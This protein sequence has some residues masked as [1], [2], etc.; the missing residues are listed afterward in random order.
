MF[1]RRF[2]V[3]LIVVGSVGAGTV[4][5]AM[6]GV[7]G[8]SGASTQNATTTQATTPA[9][10]P[11]RPRGPQGALFDAAAKALHLTTDQLKQKLSDG[12]TTI[13]DVAKQQNVDVNAVIDAM[14]A[15][16]RQR[17]EDFVNNPLPKFGAHGP[18]VH[19][20]IKAG[21][22]LSAVASA[23]GVTEDELRTQLRGGKSIAQIAKDHNV[24]VDKVIDA[25]VNAAG[26]K[27]DQAVKDGKLTAQQAE[28]A[29][30]N[31]RDRITRMM[32][33]EGPGPMKGFG[34]LGRR[35]HGPAMMP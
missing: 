11:A 13:A 21:P 14:A 6:I 29:K 7:P 28:K 25:V 35:G 32:N 3:P 23:L 9:G 1:G 30:T 27:I 17:I 18:G 33:G 10:G 19:A 34:R 12:K 4:A 2:V 20:G 8:L 22:D 24:D 26:A 5:G 16:D 15:A 31:L